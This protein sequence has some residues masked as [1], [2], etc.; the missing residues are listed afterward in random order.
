MNVL[1]GTIARMRAWRRRSWTVEIVQ[2]KP[3]LLDGAVKLGRAMYE[4][5]MKVPQLYVSDERRGRGP[6]GT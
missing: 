2:E 5:R 1:R 6:E 4:K 3:V